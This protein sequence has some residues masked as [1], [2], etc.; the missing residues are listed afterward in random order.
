MRDY[1]YTYGACF[2]QSVQSLSLSLLYIV[3]ISYF[4]TS[5][6]LRKLSIYAF[7][8]LNFYTFL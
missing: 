6:Y 7:L 4:V 1:T 8:V 2:D 5:L 3:P